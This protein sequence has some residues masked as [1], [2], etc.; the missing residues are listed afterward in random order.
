MAAAAGVT[1]IGR[2]KLV[3]MAPAMI[4]IRANSAKKMAKRCNQALAATAGSVFMSNVFFPAGCTDS[5][6]DQAQDR[7]D[8]AGDR[9][10]QHQHH[11]KGH[12]DRRVTGGSCHAARSAPY[13]RITDHR[14]PER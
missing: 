8:P 14:I 10:P 6:D 1:A 3:T 7:D 12:N 9:A 5:N 2:S 11:T 13:H 4:A